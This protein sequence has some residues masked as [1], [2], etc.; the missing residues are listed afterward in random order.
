[1]NRT[2]RQEIAAIETQLRAGH[3]QVQGLVPA[4]ADWS[5]EFRLLPNVRT[6]GDQ[7]ERRPTV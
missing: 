3:P 1:M 5:A 6:R 2:F 7:N 4:L